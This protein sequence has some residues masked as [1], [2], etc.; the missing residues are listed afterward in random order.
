MRTTALTCPE[1]NSF[2][3]GLAATATAASSAAS[4]G[5]SAGSGAA[6]FPKSSLLACHP[7]SGVPVFAA[8][9]VRHS[10]VIVQAGLAVQFPESHPHR[11]RRSCS[12]RKSNRVRRAHA[13]PAPT[14]S[15]SSSSGSQGPAR[16]SLY[17]QFC[18]CPCS[19]PY[20]WPCSPPI[21]TVDR[22][23]RSPYSSGRLALGHV[24]T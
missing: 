11:T 18:P 14:A 10:S 22:T 21:D 4:Q 9:C 3:L 20:R 16:P 7:W 24:A 8:D 6:G 5:S 1:L 2:A 23:Q 19:S 12:K 15:P 13:P 17:V